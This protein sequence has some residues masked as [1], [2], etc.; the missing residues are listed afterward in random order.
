MKG[1]HL[2]SGWINIALVAMWALEHVGI[3]AFFHIEPRNS[4]M[5][6]VGA[7]ALSLLRGYL[8]I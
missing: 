3:G 4:I 7:E 8:A 6:L 1:A 2:K 5:T